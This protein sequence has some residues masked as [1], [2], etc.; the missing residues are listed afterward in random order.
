MSGLT[1]C[2]QLRPS[3]RGEHVRAAMYGSHFQESG[4]GAD[5][6]VWERFG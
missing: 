4:C 5:I 2:R 1:P 6:G 3:S